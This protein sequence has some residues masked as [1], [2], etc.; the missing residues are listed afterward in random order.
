MPVKQPGLT[1]CIVQIVDNMLE[2]RKSQWILCVLAR[3]ISFV[4][5]LYRCYSYATAPAL[6]FVA[7]GLQ[8][9][10]SL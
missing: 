7:R 6:F 5:R 9:L 10:P 1:N 8:A 4:G 2:S 3:T